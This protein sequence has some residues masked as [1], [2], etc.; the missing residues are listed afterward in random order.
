MGEKKYQGKEAKLTDEE[1]AKLL[2]AAAENYQSHYIISR[3]TPIGF[4]LPF[5]SGRKRLGHGQPSIHSSLCPPP[6]FRFR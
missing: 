2:I 5:Y 6:C 1:K 4:W 3:Y